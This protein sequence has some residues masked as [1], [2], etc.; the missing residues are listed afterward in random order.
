MPPKAFKV[1]ET[2]VGMERTRSR[3][4]HP[5]QQ[6]KGSEPALCLVSLE[7]TKIYSSPHFMACTVEWPSCLHSYME[8]SGFPFSV[9]KGGI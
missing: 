6:S 4:G 8:D 5:K 9:L 2:G 1:E 3:Q 7:S